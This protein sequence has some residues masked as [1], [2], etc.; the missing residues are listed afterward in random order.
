[1]NGID[2]TM[3]FVFMVADAGHEHRRQALHELKQHIVGTRE[4]R[5]DRC[6]RH[7]YTDLSKQFQRTHWNGFG[8]NSHR[9]S[10]V[11]SGMR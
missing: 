7:A 9:N 2:A 6:A 10:G 5:T 11:R 1:M 3:A 8:G 4:T